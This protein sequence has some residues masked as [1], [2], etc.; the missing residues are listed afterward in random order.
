MSKFFTILREEVTKA[1]VSDVWEEAK[2]EWKPIR[3]SQESNEANL[4]CVCTHP[5]KNLYLLRNLKNKAEIEV[6]SICID[7]F[8]NESMKKELRSIISEHSH[9]QE[10]RM[11]TEALQTTQG[12]QV[13]FKHIDTGIANYN[14]ISPTKKRKPLLEAL[15]NIERMYQ[16]ADDSN[17]KFTSPIKAKKTGA[18]RLK[19]KDP[20]IVE[21]VDIRNIRVSETWTYEERSMW[22]YSIKIV[23]TEAEQKTKF[24][25]GKY[26]G[27]PFVDVLEQNRKYFLWC[28]ANLDAEDHPHVI[29]FI[30]DNKICEVP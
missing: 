28:A 22:G 25:F 5:V 15:H 1:S 13:S 17:Y 3:V 24:S 12:Y 9:E 18:W 2:N 27:V 19:V 4:E 10:V 26:A 21:G 23:P 16:L 20:E 11:I 6:G 30:V 29:E 8:K 7:L 14:L